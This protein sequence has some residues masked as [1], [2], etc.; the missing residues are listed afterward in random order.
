MKF[1]LHQAKRR[2]QAS[3]VS[4]LACNASTTS[5]SF[6]SR[7][8][9]GPVISNPYDHSKFTRSGFR[10]L[11]YPNLIFMMGFRKNR[12]LPLTSLLPLGPRA[13]IW[14]QNLFKCLDKLAALKFH[15]R[16]Q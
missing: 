7:P 9:Y 13:S 15:N 5:S 14:G 1:V 6:A 16:Y 12:I 3:E 2:S 4:S 8:K 10:R 11:S